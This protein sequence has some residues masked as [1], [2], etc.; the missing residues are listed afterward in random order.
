M[1]NGRR[2]LLLYKSRNCMRRPTFKLSNLSSWA[3]WRAKR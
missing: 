2:G 1:E 3:E